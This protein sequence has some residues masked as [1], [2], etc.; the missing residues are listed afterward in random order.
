MSKRPIIFVMVAIMLFT[1][2]T[3]PPAHAIVPAVAWAIW[4]VAAGATGVAVVAD[5]T[6]N[7]GQA[8]AKTQGQEEQRKETKSTAPELQQSPG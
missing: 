7:H 6:S 3:A 2:C 5:E 8:Q 1:F 4:A